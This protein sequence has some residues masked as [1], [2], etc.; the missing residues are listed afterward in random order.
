MPLP[1]VTSRRTWGRKN[2]TALHTISVVRSLGA[3]V[4][5]GG[6]SGHMDVVKVLEDKHEMSPVKSLRDI[7][8]RVV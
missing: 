7:P 6:T 8:F 2:C 1:A 3:T 5:Q 4:M